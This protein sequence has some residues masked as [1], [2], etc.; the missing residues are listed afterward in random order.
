[1]YEL[2][3]ISTTVEI[4]TKIQNQALKKCPKSKLKR[5]DEHIYEYHHKD[6]SITRT[7]LQNK[8]CSFQRVL[9]RGV[10][11]YLIVSAILSNVNH[12]G[13]TVEKRLIVRSVRNK[14]I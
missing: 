5:V 12:I 10:F 11:A 4:T 14:K 9:H 1:L 7:D 8:D 6:G 3:E 2:D 13:L